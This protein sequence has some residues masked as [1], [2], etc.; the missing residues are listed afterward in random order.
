MNG[1]ILSSRVSDD[2]AAEVD[3]IT[4]ANGMTRASFIEDTLKRAVLSK[5]HEAVP[6]TPVQERGH[7]DD[8]ARIGIRLH[9]REV[10]AIDEVAEPL[11]LTRA[12]WIK[13][14]I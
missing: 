9:Q 4:I 12:E 2:L 8:Y 3:R 7:P 14:T 11:G 6:L 1:V 13:R 5:T 10:E